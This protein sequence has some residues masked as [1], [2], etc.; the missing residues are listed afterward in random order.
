MGFSSD[1]CNSNIVSRHYHVRFERNQ[2][3]C[4]LGKL[5]DRALGEA[6]LDENRFPFDVAELSESLSER[7]DIGRYRHLS[8]SAEKR[9]LRDP[10]DLLRHGER[11]GEHGSQASDESAAIHLYSIT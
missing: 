4:E 6:N 8:S 2:L 10:G 5:F 1:R 11:R 7:S 9:D 3:P